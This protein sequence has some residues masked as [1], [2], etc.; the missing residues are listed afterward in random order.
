MRWKTAQW[1]E[2]RWWKNYLKDKTPVDY[3]AWK[4]NYWN[5]FLDSI[6]F[7]PVAGCAVLDAGCGPAGIFMVLNDC[8][9]TA[10]DPLLEDYDNA[11]IHFNKSDYKHVDFRSSTIE[12]LSDPAKYDA[13]FCINAINHVANIDLAYFKLIDALK[14]GGKLILSIDS[15]NY[16]LL[17]WL[18]RWLPLDIL[19]PHQFSLAEY[20]SALEHHGV[21]NVKTTL[22]K[23]GIIFNYYALVGEKV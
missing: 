8:N 16:A 13:V 21:S 14:S 5:N 12:S 20:K 17:K 23:T 9:I 18:F 6:R 11:L 3:A 4:I 15:H 7:K 22:V 19:H 2:K 1:F 10:I